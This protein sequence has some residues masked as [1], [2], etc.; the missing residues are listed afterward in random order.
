MS[1]KQRLVYG[2]VDDNLVLLPETAA[3]VFAEDHQAI[4]SLKTY[5]EARCFQRQSLN[6]VP[7]LDEDDYDDIPADGDPYNVALTNEYQNGDWPPPA[8]TIALDGLPD[9]LDDIGERIEHFPSFPT[10]HIDPGTE[11][12][13]VWVLNQRGYEVRR[14]DELISRI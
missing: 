10:L 6:G 11:A 3:K 2:I 1:T 12:D 7:G 8:A 14:D 5:G 4:W 13:L 9:D